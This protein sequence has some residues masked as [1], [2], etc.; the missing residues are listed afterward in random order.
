M[1]ILGT[2]DQK[3]RYL[4]SKA[5]KITWDSKEREQGANN[6]RGIAAMSSTDLSNI[7]ASTLLR[8]GKL[9]GSTE[10]IEILIVEDDEDDYMLTMEALEGSGI[11]F[12]VNWVKD[13]V[14]AL[15]YLYHK[16][17]YRIYNKSPRP[18]LILLDINMPRKDGLETLEELRQDPQFNDILVVVLSSYV[19]KE[20]VLNSYKLGLDSF[21]QKTGDLANF[22]EFFKI[23]IQYWFEINKVLN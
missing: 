9:I 15:D 22:S 19:Q 16:D 23:L 20:G 14:E 13:G 7:M 17:D 5:S 2:I 21:V 11:N 10:M 6:I 1:G 12:N 3:F 8:S 4:T 18:D